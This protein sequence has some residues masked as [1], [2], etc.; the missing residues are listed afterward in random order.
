[1]LPKPVLLDGETFVFYSGFVETGFVPDLLE[2]DLV[3]YADTQMVRKAVGRTFR[4]TDCFPGETI[5]C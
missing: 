1:M 4:T 3:L 2:A 5:K